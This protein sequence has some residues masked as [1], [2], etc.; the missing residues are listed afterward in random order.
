MNRI[1]SNTGSEVMNCYPE[2]SGE[3]YE[4]SLRKKISRLLLVL[5]H[6]CFYERSWQHL[7]VLASQNL[8][9]YPFNQ[10]G[11]LVVKYYHFYLIVVLIEY[12]FCDVWL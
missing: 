9:R 11:D 6:F 10:M 3:K 12:I 5:G 1:F 2:K 7:A 4:I 8:G